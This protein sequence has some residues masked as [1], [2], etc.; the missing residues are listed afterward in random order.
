M[1]RDQ[2]YGDFCSSTQKTTKEIE[3]ENT[4]CLRAGDLSFFRVAGTDRDCSRLAGSLETSVVTTRYHR[5]TL[6]RSFHARTL[7]FC[8]GMLGP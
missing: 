2:S 7:T 1:K 3:P 6:A 8:L 5:L 4:D